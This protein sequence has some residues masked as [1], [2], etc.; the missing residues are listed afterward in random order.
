MTIRNAASTVFHAITL[1]F[2]VRSYFHSSD[3]LSRVSK[4]LLN[5]LFD[6]L[7]LVAQN[8]SHAT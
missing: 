7:Q 3:L 8:D 6:G 2:I 1:R 5:S 4:R